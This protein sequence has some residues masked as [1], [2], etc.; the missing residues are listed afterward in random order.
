MVEQ[1]CTIRIVNK[2]RASAAQNFRGHTLVVLFDLRA[3]LRFL[4]MDEQ[5]IKHDYHEVCFY[6]LFGLSS[7]FW[8]KF[9]DLDQSGTCSVPWTQCRTEKF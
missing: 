9:K 4:E 7:T 1:S 6:T 3:T 8:G 2:I 5:Q